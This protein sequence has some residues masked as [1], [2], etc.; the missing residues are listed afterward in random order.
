MI[1]IYS[2]WSLP[3]SN[4]R[5]HGKLPNEYFLAYLTLSV[6]YARLFFDK[7]IMFTDTGGKETFEKYKTR[8]EILTN[9]T[10]LPFDKIETILD[11]V[12]HPKNFWAIGKIYAYQYASIVYKT[13]FIHFDYDSHFVLDII[14]QIKNKRI[15]VEHIENENMYCRYE[16]YGLKKN[17]Y[18]Y[19][20]GVFGGCDLKHIAEYCEGALEIADK[21]RRFT[22]EN[23]ISC[24]FEQ[25]YLYDFCQAKGIIPYTILPNHKFEYTHFWSAKSEPAN[26]INTVNKLM[27][28]YGT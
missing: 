12:P 3:C 7:V 1:A 11:G 14:P 2:H 15:I 21:L 18:A 28:V 27:S 16:N 19:N 5:L 25:K 22:S 9:T 23:L 10:Y 13:P 8:S 4:G 20:T 24:M 17:R 6:K 26:Y